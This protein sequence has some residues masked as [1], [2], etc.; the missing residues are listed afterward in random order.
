MNGN[1]EEMRAI[2]RE[3][4]MKL[5]Y[6]VDIN[7]QAKGERSLV[8]YLNTPTGADVLD[9]QRTHLLN[10]KDEMKYF[11][12]TFSGIIEHLSEIDEK[13]N[14]YTKSSWNVSQFGYIERAI[15]RLAVY[16]LYWSMEEGL[17]PKVIIASALDLA[18]TFSDEKG[19]KFIHGIL[20]GMTN[21]IEVKRETPS[22]KSGYQKLSSSKQKNNLDALK[23]FNEAKRKNKRAV[24]VEVESVQNVEETE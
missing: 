4:V 21:Q 15:L 23:K 6:M 1:D 19:I 3:K 18:D 17:S 20:G 10:E 8:E 24:A 2:T 5:V 16:E 13:V 7:R 22:K 12:A 11:D 9:F 14:Q